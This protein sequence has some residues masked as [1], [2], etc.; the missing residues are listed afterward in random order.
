MNV[1]LIAM[2][3][4]AAGCNVKYYAP[5]CIVV[6][7]V[8]IR[9]R[10]RWLHCGMSVQYIQKPGEIPYMLKKLKVV[11]LDSNQRMKF[12]ETYHSHNNNKK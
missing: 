1:E 4:Q 3:L 6:E 5:G 9:I 7:G 8:T 11:T 2:A 10:G 12:Q